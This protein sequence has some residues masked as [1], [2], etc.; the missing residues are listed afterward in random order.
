MFRKVIC[1]VLLASISSCMSYTIYERKLSTSNNFKEYFLRIENKN[2]PIFLEFPESNSD[3]FDEIEIQTYRYREDNH[4]FP[5][6]YRRELISESFFSV[7]DI[8]SSVIV[9]IGWNH[10]PYP[11]SRNLLP[12]E[13]SVDFDSIIKP[14][15]LALSDKRWRTPFE[16]FRGQLDD[17]H[18]QIVVT[19]KIHPKLGFNQ[20]MISH[21]RSSHV[22]GAEDLLNDKQ[23]YQIQTNKGL[24]LGEIEGNI[25]RLNKDYISDDL[26]KVAIGTA[27]FK[28]ILEECANLYFF[29]ETDQDEFDRYTE[30]TKYTV[31]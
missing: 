28:R 12:L 25:I 21:S 7:G 22:L 27:T 5:V 18:I 2:A 24:L 1:L 14:E 20:D 16:L 10:S 11:N 3:E 31:K 17:K 15:S 30:Y 8:K 29:N 4:G 19:R 13:F 6:L 9:K 23:L 26:L